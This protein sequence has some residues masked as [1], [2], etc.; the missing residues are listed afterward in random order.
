MG[1]TPKKSVLSRLYAIVPGCLLLAPFFVTSLGCNKEILQLPA[2]EAKLPRMIGSTAAPYGLEPMEVMGYGVVVGLPG[3]GGNVP[4]GPA[5]SAALGML[6]QQK[7]DKP[8]EFLASKEAAVVLVIGKIAPGARVG[9]LFDVEVKC[10]DEDRQTTSLRGGFLLLSSLKDVADVR[11]L[12]DKGGNPE[13][14]TGF[15]WA[16]A[17]G[18]VMLATGQESD[19]RKG[20]VVAGAR[21]KKE[22]PLALLIRS[23]YSKKADQAM[24]IGAAIDERFRVQASGSF[25][26]IADPKDSKYIT[27]RVPDQY[28]YNIPR[29]LEVLTRIPYEAG[30][31]EKMMW[32]KQCAE[33]LLNPDKCF[34]A[35]LRLESLGGEVQPYLL[36]GCKHQHL[37][38]KF[39]SAEALA[40]LGV[41]SEAADVLA[42]VA[43]KSP[44][45]R[46]YALTALS[47]VQDTACATRLRELMSQDSVETRYGAFVALRTAHPTDL[48]LKM[49]SSRESGY[50]IYEVAPQSRPML[51]VSTTGKPEIVFFGKGHALLAPCSLTAGPELVVTLREGETEC[52]VS[53][54]EVGGKVVKRRC[55]ANLPAV[56]TQC[57]Q[58]GA[59]YADVVDFLKQA[60]M[61]HNLECNLVV[62][63]MPRLIPWSELARA[64]LPV[65]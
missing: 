49:M 7:M 3:T 11:E 50:S 43:R 35:A 13:Y 62:D 57:M 61:G 39:A 47:A 42:E 29:Y 12:S 22:R 28:R 48:G 64:E 26:K 45:M 30:S 27:L 53:L 58:L 24:L 6:T 37:K 1:V 33:D 60:S 10:L 34:E 63:G 32:Q 38:V 41:S 56:L 14:R 54:T 16:F 23:E 65:Q 36:R 51:H 55:Q 44:E 9:D 31:T 21:L 20:R 4:Q 46:P 15:E 8:A 2:R 40:Y 52:T 59:S 25:A 17:N 18:P 19:T 5:R